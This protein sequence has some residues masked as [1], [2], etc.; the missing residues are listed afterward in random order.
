MAGE[1]RIPA[2]GMA[3]VSSTSMEQPQT[4]ND[5]AYPDDDHIPI[6]PEGIMQNIM[7]TE[8]VD[9]TGTHGNGEWANGL[10]V[11]QQVDVLD[12]MGYWCE[13]EILKIDRVNR[14]IYVTFLYWDKSWDDWISDFEGRVAPLHTHTYVEGGVLKLRQRIEA[15]DKTNKWLEAFVIEVDDAQALVK[16]HYKGWH[17]KFDEW[18]DQRGARIRPYGRHKQIARKREQKLWRVPGT[19]SS[20]GAA[21]STIGG[22]GN[23]AHSSSGWN[24]VGLGVGVGSSSRG[25]LEYSNG[26]GLKGEG[27]GHGPNAD[28]STSSGGGD[29]DYR[30]RR[31][32]NGNDLAAESHSHRAG[33]TGANH[34]AAAAAACDYLGHADM[35]IDQSDAHQQQHRRQIEELSD[36]YGHY[37][38]A[39]HTHH[40]KVVPVPGDGNCLFRAVAHQVYG[41]HELHDLVSGATHP[42][43]S[44]PYLSSH[45]DPPSKI[46]SHYARFPPLAGA[47]ALS[48]LHGG[49]RRVLLAVR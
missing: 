13:A 46:E 23:G 9:L 3:S 39:L 40:L 1:R 38:G 2:L 6:N 29:D 15:L 11:G 35:T 25:G 42:T 47:A 18:L 16:V 22:G 37:I 33:W 34:R 32:L 43:S 44:F 21:S 41:D 8:E 7:V 49:G 10:A 30:H 4:D 14:K 26:Y 20:M 24:N 45:H 36:R 17:V 31:D 5:P 28:P 27:P 12:S 48:G 19:I